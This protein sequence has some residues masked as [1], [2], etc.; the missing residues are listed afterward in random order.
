M[1]QQGLG[2]EGVTGE[3]PRG[4][5]GDRAGWWDRQRLRGLARLPL[6]ALGP[7]H[8]SGGPQLAEAPC[9][10]SGPFRSWL[11]SPGKPHRGHLRQ[12]GFA[13]Q[14]PVSPGPTAAGGAGPSVTAQSQ[15][16]AMLRGEV[17]R[18]VSGWKGYS[19]CGRQELTRQKEGK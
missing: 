15:V 14:S 7:G 19:Q 9:S 13:P 18:P 16:Q 8:Q 2:R 6:S 4:R 1:A 3:H 10:P 11:Q 17:G 5:S 12:E